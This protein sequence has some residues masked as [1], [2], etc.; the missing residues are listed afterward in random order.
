MAKQ[1]LANKYR[2][3]TWEDVVE[4]GASVEILKYQID[5]NTFK[6]CMLFCGAAGVGKAQPLTS[7]VFTPTGYVYMKDI[8]AGDSVVDGEGKETKVLGIYPQGVRDVY[9]IT[10]NDHSSIRVSKEHLNTVY[11]YNEDTKENEWFTLETDKLIELF[12]TS[13]YNLRVGRPVIDC[14]EH[15]DVPIDPYLLGVLIGDGSLSRNFG[16]STS[17]EDIRDKVNT[18][19]EKDWDMHLHKLPGENVDYS[20]IHNNRSLQRYIYTYKDNIYKGNFAMVDALVKEGYPKFDG[21]TIYRIS[22]NNA[23]KVLNKYPELKNAIKCDYQESYTSWNDT[24]TLYATLKRLGLLCKSVD[25]HIPEEYLYNDVET[26][27]QLLR[28]LM[29]TDGDTT[30]GFATSSKQLSEDFAQLV[31]SLGIVDSIK[32]NKGRYKHNGEWIECNDYYSHYM[33]VPKDMQI[34]TSNKHVMNHIPPQHEPIRKIVSIEYDGQEECQCIY[35]E[36][37][38]HLYLTDNLVPTHNTTLARIVAK[39]INKNKGTPIEIDA[40]SNNGVDNV[41]DIIIRAQQKS[42]DSEYKC[43]II[44]ETHALSNAAWQAFLK[45]LEQPPAKT[46]FIFCTTDPQKIPATILSRIQRFNFARISFKGICDRLRYIVECEHQEDSEVV[47]DDGAID[48]IAKFADGGMRASIAFLDKCLS[49]NKHVTLERAIEALGGINYDIMFKLIDSIYDGNESEVINIIE[50]VYREGADLKLFL[51]QFTNFVLDVC[52]YINFGN[53]DY[54]QIPQTYTPQLNNTIAVE[55]RN[56]FK[57]VLKNVNELNTTCKWEQN[58]KPLIEL[59]MLIW[60][61]PE[62]VQ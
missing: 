41:R 43:F 54:I 23:P 42:L 34:Y 1:S 14:W 37:E 28:G 3:Q 11:R 36:S 10:F 22:Q 30:R 9:K 12:K 24:T 49:F 50:S 46:I 33:R 58:C 15:K 60:C 18:I 62:G 4:Q 32:C 20:I 53:F 21:S 57:Q 2:P 5:T 51:K 59:N 25:K 26:R 55:D 16:F 7:K 38:N 44:D 19:L 27:L 45:T 39:A 40:A 8:K 47:V 52:K 6:N 13:H 56:F 35:V 48:F 29:D 61:K 31:R 17:E